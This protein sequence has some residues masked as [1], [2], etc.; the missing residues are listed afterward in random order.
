MTM[1]KISVLFVCLGNICRSPM[2]EFIFKDKVQ[3]AG[4]SEF[5]QIDSAGTAGWHSGEGMHCGTADMLDLHKIESNGFRS[6]QVRK[7]DITQFDYIIGMDDSNIEDLERLFGHYPE[8]IFKI[9]NLC[10]QLT[11]DHIPDPWY[12]HNFAETYSLLDQCCEALLQKIKQQI[13][14]V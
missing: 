11:K 2:A 12:T 13:D 10:P 9:T 7:Q 1:H 6:R 3:K 8:Q 5:I 4:L 14:K